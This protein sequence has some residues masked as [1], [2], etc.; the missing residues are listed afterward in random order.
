MLVPH[1]VLQTGILN[2]TV[3]KLPLVPRELRALTEFKYTLAL[4]PF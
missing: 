1:L 4:H 2:Q 3:Q